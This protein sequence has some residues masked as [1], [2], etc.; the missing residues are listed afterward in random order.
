MRSQMPYTH[1][2]FT[3]FMGPFSSF[4]GP[5]TQTSDQFDDDDADQAPD[6]GGA[7]ARAL[8]AKV[9]APPTGGGGGGASGAGEARRV[10]RPLL[11]SRGEIDMS[12]ARRAGDIVMVKLKKGPALTEMRVLA[13][14][15]PW[16]EPKAGCPEVSSKDVDDRDALKRAW[17]NRPFDPMYYTI[18]CDME[19]GADSVM[20]V[21]DFPN[22]KHLSSH[23]MCVHRALRQM[24]EG[25]A[26]RGSSLAT[27]HHRDIGP[28]GP[29][30]T[31]F[32]FLEFPEDAYNKTKKRGAA[33]AEAP[34][35]PPA[36]TLAVAFSAPLPPL[37]VEAS[38]AAP[39]PPAPPRALVKKGSGSRAKAASAAVL[40]VAAAV[41]A[42][43]PAAAAAPSA[44]GAVDIAFLVERASDPSPAGHMVR[45]LLEDMLAQRKAGM[46]E[47]ER[48]KSL[49]GLHSLCTTEHM[50]VA[51]IEAFIKHEMAPRSK[52]KADA[53]L[54]AVR[55]V[56][57]LF[58][59]LFANVPDTFQ[60]PGSASKKRKA[61]TLE[62]FNM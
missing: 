18:L 61:I 31:K 8:P 39:M 43:A 44:A 48:T 14:G 56:R 20:H 22:A 21:L 62:E 51:E 55:L 13:P 37:A 16:Q 47:S 42:S 50:S 4:A 1:T 32:R 30:H 49:W 41:A 45:A 54:Y 27:A 52:E 36:P 40:P 34:E 58:G 59:T 53:A 28:V 26:G 3:T 33:A 7:M 5:R 12:K 24:H 2:Q 46:P 15:A 10:L 29:R 11:D 60:L 25:A 17:G 19:Y 38:P 35:R 6:E 23:N 57:G 9:A